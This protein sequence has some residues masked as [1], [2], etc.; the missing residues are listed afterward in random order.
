MLA[1]THD[2]DGT[3]LR[4]AIS[5]EARRRQMERFDHFAVP[6]SWGAGY[7]KL[8]R[9]VPYCAGYPTTD[10]AGDLVKRLIDPVLSVNADGKVWPHQSQAWT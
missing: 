10:L 8:S 1:T 6:A 7:V 2:I 4:N 5:T 3:A 9:S